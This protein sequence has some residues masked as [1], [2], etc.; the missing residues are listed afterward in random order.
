[1]AAAAPPAHGF[2]LANGDKF[3]VIAADSV[4]S[5]VTGQLQLSDGTW[6]LSALPVQLSTQWQKWIGSIDVGRLRHSNLVLVRTMASANPGILDAEQVRLH[7]HLNDV[8]VL[9]QLSG[10]LEYAGAIWLT[11]SV[12]VTGSVVQQIGTL[13]QFYRTRGSRRVAVTRTRLDEATR[14]A[15]TLQALRA[16]PNEFERLVRGLQALAEGLVHSH[17]RDRLHQ[18]VRAIEALILPRTG[19]TRRDFV[20]RCQTLLVPHR[21][22]EALLG[23]VFDMRSDTEHLHAWDRSLHRFPRAQRERAALRRTR[24]IERLACSAYRR[25]FEDAALRGHFR[26]DVTQ[27]AF[28]ALPE[29]Q[30][31]AAWGRPLDIMRVT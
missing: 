10:G 5:L 6:T 25:I 16:T 23:E 12:L 17:G 1:M 22:L 28:W 30:R 13:K 27:E 24:Q 11:G 7:E 31:K 2:Q 21:R 14:A 9:L 15:V 18:F 19:R 4:H 20:H 26:T 3:A 8:F 29:N